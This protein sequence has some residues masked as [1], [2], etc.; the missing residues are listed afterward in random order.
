M[1][2]I[3]LAIVS[4]CH[5]WKKPT[6]FKIAIDI[7]SLNCSYSTNPR[8]NLMVNEH[9]E[10][11]GKLQ[12]SSTMNVMLGLM[13]NPIGGGLVASVANANICVAVTLDSIRETKN[14]H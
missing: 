1:Q 10:A 8:G 7:L 14:N 9:V 4:L 5:T 13:G 6:V 3:Q 2:N 12:D 11:V